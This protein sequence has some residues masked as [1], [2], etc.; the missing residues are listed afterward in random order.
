MVIGLLYQMQISYSQEMYA[1]PTP[2]FQRSQYP[3]FYSS[4]QPYQSLPSFT[5]TPSTI[6][7]HNQLPVDMD[8]GLE[9]SPFIVPSQ[10]RDTLCTDTRRP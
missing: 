5:P 6:Q 2:Q 10:H 4:T 3:R 9:F 8:T 1:L 7:Y